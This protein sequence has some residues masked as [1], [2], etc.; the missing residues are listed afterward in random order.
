VRDKLLLKQNEYEV[1]AFGA[2]CKY[3]GKKI[4]DVIGETTYRTE[5]R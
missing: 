4:Q 1:R 5:G 2:A 3:H